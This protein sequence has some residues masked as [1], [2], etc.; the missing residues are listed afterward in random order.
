V[1]EVPEPQ[2]YQGRDAIG[3]FPRD[4]EFRRDAPL[5]L[6]PTRANTDPAFG[7]C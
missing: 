7:C 6:V 1:T 4:R 2:E 3:V 5:R